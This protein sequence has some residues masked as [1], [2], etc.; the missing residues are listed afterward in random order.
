MSLC[1]LFRP[2][3]TREALYKFC[4]N[5]SGHSAPRTTESF[6]FF[7]TC[8]FPTLFFFIYS[9]SWT[10]LVPF[11]RRLS[12]AHATLTHRFSGLAFARPAQR[13]LYAQFRILIRYRELRSRDH[14]GDEDIASH[15]YRYPMAIF[16]SDHRGNDD[17][18]PFENSRPL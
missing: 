12:R 1:T 3:D 5:L 14:L 17:N 8:P 18:T 16:T 10:E 4:W 6:V 9:W 7:S 11:E 2:L 15:G 13:D